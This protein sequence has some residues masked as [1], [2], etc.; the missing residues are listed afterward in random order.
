MSK[1]HTKSPRGHIRISVVA[2][3]QLVR[4]SLGFLL[5]KNRRFTLVGTTGLN[6]ERSGSAK[7]KESDIVVVYLEP[8]DPADV[9]KELHANFPNVKIIAI[10]DGEDLECSMKALKFGAVGIIRSVQG[11]NLLFE[12]IKKAYEGETWL[13]QELL[14][15]L[16]ENG[17]ADIPAKT[18]GKIGYDND[19]LTPREIE[20]ISMLGKGLKS[21]VIAE[22]MSISAATVRHHLSSIYG[23][24]GVEDRLNLVIFAF[25]KG[26]IKLGNDSVDD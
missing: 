10:T 8:G 18:N 13:D 7:I 20:V 23:K 4:E 6:L 17:N 1:T 15:I 3:P 22:R 2:T 11:S 9:V 26:L 14:T 24:L 21:K 25:E 16:L 12:A 19:W 5:E